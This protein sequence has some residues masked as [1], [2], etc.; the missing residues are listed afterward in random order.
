MVCLIDI[1]VTKILRI[2]L[3]SHIELSLIMFKPRLGNWIMVNFEGSSLI[4]SM[5]FFPLFL[6]I[7]FNIHEYGYNIICISNHQIKL[8]CP[9]INMEP[10]LVF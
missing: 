5:S 10:S 4:F 9:G 3:D 1:P 7:P 8:L 2:P 6:K